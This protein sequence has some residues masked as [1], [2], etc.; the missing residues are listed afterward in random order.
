LDQIH[1][2]LWFPAFPQNALGT[3]RKG[4][5]SNHLCVAFRFLDLLSFAIPIFFMI[6]SRPFVTSTDDEKSKELTKERFAISP[7][8]IRP[9]FHSVSSKQG[10]LHPSEAGIWH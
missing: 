1:I 7:P 6:R 3:Q 2:S 5:L 8:H 9:D 10:Q 4:L